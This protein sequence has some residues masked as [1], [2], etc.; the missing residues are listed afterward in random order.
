MIIIITYGTV[1]DRD[2]NEILIVLTT[3]KLYI[4]VISQ[5]ECDQV[6]RRFG[7]WVLGYS[8]CLVLEG[9]ERG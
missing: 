1:G 7:S 9:L 4:L 6:P 8:L 5:V 3:W 2:L